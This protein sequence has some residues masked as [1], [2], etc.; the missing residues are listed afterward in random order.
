MH[1]TEHPKETLQL[2]QWHPA[3]CAAVRLELKENK[4]QL[5][6][7]S[8]YG[9]NTK[10]I[11]IDLLVIIKSP[12]VKIENEIGHIFKGHN[13][14]EYKSPK[15]HMTIDTFYK[16]LAYAFLYKT[17]TGNVDQI[18]ADDMTVSLVREKRP[19]KLFAD[20]EK[21]GFCLREI[22]GGIY[23]V[24]N[25]MGTE[26]QV[27]VSGELNQENHV[28]LRSLTQN[29]TKKDAEALLLSSNYLHEDDEKELAS[30]VLQVAIKEN[31][32]M[33]LDLKEARE[34]C[35]A[36]RELM[37][38]EIDAVIKEA[39]AEKEAAIAKAVAEKEEEKDAAIAKVVAEK[40]ARIRALEAQLAALNA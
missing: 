2:T 7:Q 10:P 12:E 40:D 35:E 39:E 1:N 19:K 3:F 22:A 16:S 9:L 25:V 5:T 28:W 18:K 27:I 26:I 8:E 15:D 31:K 4:G 30:S 32:T 36:L 21:L 29:L 13:I 20:L 17:N 34:M 37:K 38:P 33:F 11:Q 24:G 14:F 6:Y 23:H